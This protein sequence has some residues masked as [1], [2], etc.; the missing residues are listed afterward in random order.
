MM[1]RDI[2]VVA[3][4]ERRYQAFAAEAAEYG[5]EVSQERWCRFFGRRAL[6][7]AQAEVGRLQ[8]IQAFA[9]MADRLA[10]FVKRLRGWMT[11]D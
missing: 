9:P 8:L 6:S 1:P 11:P 5:E 2:G 3:G 10:V 4:L 7:F